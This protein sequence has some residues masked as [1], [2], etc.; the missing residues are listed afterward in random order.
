MWIHAAGLRKTSS[1]LEAT[2]IPLASQSEGIVAS[3]LGLPPGM[4]NS[5][6][7]ADDYR[8]ATAL[9]NTFFDTA[10][11]SLRGLKRTD[12]A[13]SQFLNPEIT[14]VLPAINPR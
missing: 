12:S 7:A 2:G 10:V 4:Q 9:S 13:S 3:E 1:Q 6:Q 5:G 8:L 11:T 14:S